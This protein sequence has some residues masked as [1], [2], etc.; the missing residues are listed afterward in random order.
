ME[1]QSLNLNEPGLFGQLNTQWRMECIS[2]KPPN[3]H[4]KTIWFPTE[5]IEVE[6]KAS[7]GQGPGE[8]KFCQN[9]KTRDFRVKNI[10]K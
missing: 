2:G 9:P 10:H 3:F 8:K 1:L 7:S 5:I 6:I 4:S